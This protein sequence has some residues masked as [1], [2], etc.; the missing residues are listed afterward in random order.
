MHR[1][2]LLL[3]LVLVSNLSAQTNQPYLKQLL[4]I[5]QQ[6]QMYRGEQGFIHIQD[7]LDADNRKRLD[8]LYGK[9]GFPTLRQVGEKGVLA[10]LLVLHH[11]VD[12]KWNKRWVGYCL[13]NYTEW[14]NDLKLMQYMFERTY[15][16]DLG[17]CRADQAFLKELVAC[18]DQDLISRMGI[19]KWIK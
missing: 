2:Y 8:K 17:P 10:V 16:G 7:S 14:P 6:D 13:D 5:D 19:K 9:Y 18:Y 12:C 3:S 1:L 15:G 4:K 11:S